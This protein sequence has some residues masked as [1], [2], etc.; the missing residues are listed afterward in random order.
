MEKEESKLKRFWRWYVKGEYHCEHCPYCWEEHYYE[1]DCDCGCIIRGDIR[2]TCRLLPP[3]RFLIGWPRRRKAE[4]WASH[5]YD[6]IGEHY[7]KTHEQQEILEKELLKFLGPY[8]VVYHPEWAEVLE[9]ENGEKKWEKTIVVNKEELVASHV[10]RMHM[11]YEDAAHPYVHKTLKQEWKELIK[12][13]WNR[14][15]DKFRPYLPEK[16]KKKNE[17]DSNLV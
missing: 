14:F 8:E 3:F 7:E 16:R 11:D 9:D 4:Y 10:S 6:D 15:A 13:T 1:G 12:K 5:Q 17:L 2:D